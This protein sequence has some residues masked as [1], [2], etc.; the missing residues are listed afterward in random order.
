MSPMQYIEAIPYSVFTKDELTILEVS[1]QHLSKE[2]FKPFVIDSIGSLA[3]PRFGLTNDGVT[4]ATRRLQHRE[5]YKAFSKDDLYT[6]YCATLELQLEI[7]KREH[8][9]DP[10]APIAR[11]PVDRLHGKILQLRGLDGPAARELLAS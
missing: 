9:E 2:D 6:F 4:E 7:S 1:M 11:S 8:K 10:L 5:G 3:G